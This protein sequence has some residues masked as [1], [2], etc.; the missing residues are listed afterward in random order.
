MKQGLKPIVIIN[1]VD[2]P[3]ARVKDVESEILDMFIEMEVNED[4]LDYPVY[5]ASGREGWAVSDISE[6]T[7]PTKNGVK[8]VMDAIV[9][10]VPYP[11]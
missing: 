8:C 3:T 2:R 7:A 6:I 11:K 1:K 5:Y 10:H 4:L 9:E